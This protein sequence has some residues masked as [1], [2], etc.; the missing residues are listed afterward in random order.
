MTMNRNLFVLVLSFFL[1]LKTSAQISQ[2]ASTEKEKR[3]AKNSP[4][5][6]GMN[7]STG[8]RFIQGAPRKKVI[9][10]PAPDLKST[11]SANYTLNAYAG[12]TGKVQH[13]EKPVLYNYDKLPVSV[14]QKLDANKAAGRPIMTG[15]CK[16]YDISIPSIQTAEDLRSSL[17][18]LSRN[19]S[20]LKT[21]F[22]SSGKIYVL[23]KPEMASEELKAILSSKNVSFDFLQEQFQLIQ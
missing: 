8:G 14:K 19:G 11:P 15:I 3:P 23:A 12:S 21:T 22:I 1:V 18:D 9:A 10:V 4:E 20:V 16:R 2:S 13:S 5:N 17:T 7:K 6:P